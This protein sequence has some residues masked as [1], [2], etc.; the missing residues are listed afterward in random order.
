MIMSMQTVCR[1]RATSKRVIETAEVLIAGPRGSKNRKCSIVF[2]R[3][4]RP[5]ERSDTTFLRGC[6]G[7]RG[8][9]DAIAVSQPDRR[10]AKL[11][12]GAD[13]VFRLCCAT[14]KTEGTAGMKFN[15]AGRRVHV[16]RLHGSLGH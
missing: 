1:W 7:S 10:I 8:S 5:N 6:M 15:E 12:G 9:V 4:F 14:Q 2:H 16:V 13:E 3:Q 11:G